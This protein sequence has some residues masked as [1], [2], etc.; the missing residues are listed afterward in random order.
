MNTTSLKPTFM[1][2]EEDNEGYEFAK[3]HFEDL[4]RRYVAN[5]GDTGTIHVFN[6]VKQK[7]GEVNES[8]VGTAFRTFC[9]FAKSDRTFTPD[10]NYCEYDFLKE[11]VSDLNTG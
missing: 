3:A 10:I 2:R 5:A 9:E 6:L 8:L 4:H 1:Y 7:Q 11:K